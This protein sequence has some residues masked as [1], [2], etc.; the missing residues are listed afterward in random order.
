[1]AESSALRGL[2]TVQAIRVFQRL[3]YVVERVTSG[4]MVLEHPERPP[5]Q[6]P[7]RGIEAVAEALLRRQARVAGVS[8]AELEAAIPEPAS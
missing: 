7:Y 6:L 2:T 4:H 1:M 3:G 5:L 8:V